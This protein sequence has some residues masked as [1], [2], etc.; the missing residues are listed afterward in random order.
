MSEQQRILREY[1][2]RAR[3]IPPDYYAPTKLANLFFRHSTHRA[4]LQMLSQAECLPLDRRRILDI[5]CGTGQWLIDF[6]TWGATRRYLAGIDLIP[7]RARVARA[8]LAAMRDAEGRII[9]PGA[10]IREGDAGS[11]PWPDQS[12]EIVSQSMMFSS[13]LDASLRRRIA[14]EMQRVLV[15]EGIVI[16]YDF[17]VDNP[18]NPS[19]RGVRQAEVREFF[20]EFELTHR[21][22]TLL[23][24]LARRLVPISWVAA[25]ILERLKLLNT[26][27][28][29]VLRA[30]K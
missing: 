24:P 18:S 15:P 29:L 5:G 19:V 20:P 22:V 7:D 3:D 13:I 27:L 6:E 12:F 14:S 1:Q 8:R 25:E 26:H 21:R 28:L 4:L 10:D 17:F 30:P 23:P 9:S 11:L 2:R 16:W